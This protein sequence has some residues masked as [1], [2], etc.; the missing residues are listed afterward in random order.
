MSLVLDDA[1]PTVLIAQSEVHPHFARAGLTLVQPEH[2][3][4]PLSDA[5]EEPALSAP[6][7]TAYVLYT[8]GSTGQPKGVEVTHRNLC[9]FLEGMQRQLM[10][11]ASD[12]FLAVTNLIFDIAGLELYLPLTAGACVVIA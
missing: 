9:N 4:A 10:P 11:T 12:R 8:S 3:D 5:A 7:R 1:L 2:P 6:E